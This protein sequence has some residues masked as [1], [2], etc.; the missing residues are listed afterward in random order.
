LSLLSAMPETLCCGRYT[1]NLDRPLVMGIVN[2]TSDSFSGDGLGLNASAAIRQAAT[3]IEQGADCLDIG[4]ESSRP[5]AE[6]VS[7]QQELDAVLPVLEAV[8]DCGVPISIDTVKPEVMRAA[9]AGGA[10]LIN[11]ISALADAD[12]MATVAASGAAVCLMHMRGAPRT[13]QKDP[14]Y[15]DVVRE[16]GEYLGARAAAAAAAGIDRDRIIVDP[17]FGFGKTLAHNLDLLRHLDRI[18]ALGWPVLV[19]MSRKSMLGALTGRPT[20]ER[21][22]AGVAAAVLAAQ[23]G[24]RIFRV[25]N[26]VAARDAL[27]IWAAVAAN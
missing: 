7:L 18:V 14:Q 11:D 10:D 17:G 25:H 24:A 19:G 13:M 21:E 15:A 9:L 20:G 2:V 27:A 23:R 3:L 22:Y 5:G 26:V 6:P 8:R 16:V 4:G 12:A 1:L